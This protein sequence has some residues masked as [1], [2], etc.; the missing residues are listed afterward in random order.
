MLN[1][2][3][4]LQRICCVQQGVTMSDSV[5]ALPLANLLS[6]AQPGSV[7]ALLSSLREGLL[8]LDPDLDV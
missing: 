7:L 8:I 1:A 3:I 6:Q 5:R 2:T 4:M